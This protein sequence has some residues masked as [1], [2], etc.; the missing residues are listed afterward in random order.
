MRLSTKQSNREPAPPPEYAN[1]RTLRWIGVFVGCVCLAIAS[2]A[3]W[4]IY[5]LS[6]RIGMNE[7]PLEVANLSQ[8]VSPINFGVLERV[9]TIDKEKKSFILLPIEWDAFYGYTITTTPTSE[10]T[11]ISM[12]TTTTSLSSPSSSDPL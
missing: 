1:V 3:T 4:T 12:P 6:N 10:T 2:Y 5:T 11:T 7:I 9:H 8:R